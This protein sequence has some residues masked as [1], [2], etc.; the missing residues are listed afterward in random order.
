VQKALGPIQIPLDDRPVESVSRAFGGNCGGRD[1]RIRSHLVERFTRS[2][3]EQE[4]R[5][6][7]DSQ[8]QTGSVSDPMKYVFH[9]SISG[10][11]ARSLPIIEL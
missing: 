8:K 4:K 10:N 11:R 6:Y 1:L 3:R 5:K 9:L 2:E 7:G